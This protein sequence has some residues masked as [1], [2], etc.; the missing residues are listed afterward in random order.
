MSHDPNQLADTVILMIKAALTPTLERLAAIEARLSA[1]PATDKAVGEL[2]DRLLVMETKAAEPV[3]VP[4]V[5]MSPVLQ[6]VAVAESRIDRLAE[7]EKALGDVRDRLLVCEKS[8]PVQTVPEPVDLAPV[9]ERVAEL[10]EAISVKSAAPVVDLSPVTARLTQLETKAVPTVSDLSSLR[11]DVMSLRERMVAV[12]TRG[13]VPGPPGPKGDNGRDG[14]NGKDGLDG[15]GF[16][17][18]TVVQDDERS[19]TVKAI[20]GDRV[21]DIGRASFPVEIY[22]GVYV[23]GR[24]YERG[25]CVT[26]A[27]SEFHCNEATTSKPEES[28]AWQLKVKRGRDGRDGKDA[29][30]MPVVSVR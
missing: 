10:R 5:D 13:A 27:G 23:A 20:K 2:K 24:T 9:L 29:V 17:G 15:V 11:D 6:R 7:V 19:L 14:Q 22:R 30:S 1:L 8:T 28:K 18:L 3:D 26:Y 21:K 4:V 25:D 16:D 12:E